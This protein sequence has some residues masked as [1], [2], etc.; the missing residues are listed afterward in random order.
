MTQLNYIEY[1]LLSPS[2]LPGD[3]GGEG[4]DNEIDFH[5]SRLPAGRRG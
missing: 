3:G 5:G 2:S 1:S 4:E